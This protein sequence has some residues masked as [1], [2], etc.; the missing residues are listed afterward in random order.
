MIKNPYKNAVPKQKIYILYIYM[1]N[2]TFNVLIA[3][4]GRPSL[5]QMLESLKSELLEN[6]CLTIVFDGCTQQHIEILSEFSCKIKIYEENPALGF[7][8]HAI[9]AKYRE[10]LEPR[11][12]IMHADDDDTYISGSFDIL[13]SLCV[14]PTTL[15]ISKMYGRL[16]DGIIPRNAT[17]SAGNIG[18]PNGIIPYHLNTLST[19][20][21]HVHGDGMM[22]EL[23]AKEQA[24]LG[25][26]I[27]FLPTIIYTVGR[28]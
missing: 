28:N 5:V 10:L 8:G 7:Y 15:Y 26:E 23:L 21:N 18:T 1:A 24:A 13:R 16:H 6:D 19:W 20:V 17:I 3:T 14:N 11:T 2:N 27:V 22:Y 9:R 12:F 25:N 4:I